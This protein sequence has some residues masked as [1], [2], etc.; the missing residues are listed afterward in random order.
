LIGNYYIYWAIAAVII[1]A[2]SL[3]KV[4]LCGEHIT[5]RLV[6]RQNRVIIQMY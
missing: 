2:Y 1:I 3:G 6:R 5:S 4:S